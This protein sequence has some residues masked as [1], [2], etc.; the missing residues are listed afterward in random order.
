MSTENHR[1]VV[2]IFTGGQV[3]RV[4]RFIETV[5]PRGVD[6]TVL[7]AEGGQAW[8]RGRELHP[9]ARTVSIGQAENRQPLV[10]LYLACIERGPNIILRRAAGTL[11]GALGK[12]AGRAASLHGKVARRTRRRLFWPVY[13]MVRGQALRRLARRRIDRLE[14]DRAERVIVVDDTAVPFGWML[15]RRYSGLQVTRQLDRNLYDP[16]APPEDEAAALR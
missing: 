8:K 3:R 10:W 4:N 16:P 11:P 2:V 6:V 7:T 12:A 5:G 1:V 14:L 9:A 13:K 15:A